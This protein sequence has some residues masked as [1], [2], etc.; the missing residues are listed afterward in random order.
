MVRMEVRFQRNKFVSDLL[1][2]EE[3]DAFFAEAMERFKGEEIL[4]IDVD[5]EGE[6]V[7]S[8]VDA[9]EALNSLRKERNARS[10]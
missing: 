9:E 7:G 8:M 5:E 3:S 2:Q 1:S 4:C 6:F 10:G